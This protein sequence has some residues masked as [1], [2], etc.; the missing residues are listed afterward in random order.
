MTRPKIKI[1]TW[2][3]GEGCVT[4]RVPV[5]FQNKCECVTDPQPERVRSIFAGVNAT[6]TSGTGRDRNANRNRCE[7]GLRP[8]WSHPTLNHFEQCPFLIFNKTIH[9]IV[10]NLSIITQKRVVPS[11][12][13]HHLACNTK[14]SRQRQPHKFYRIIIR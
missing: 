14:S 13:L 7:H 3:A 10:I 8:S 2:C 11:A 6:R 12:P 5:A 9:L 4:V 1:K